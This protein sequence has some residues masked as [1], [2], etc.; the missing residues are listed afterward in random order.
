MAK[1]QKTWV[2]SPKRQPEP[3]VPEAVKAD[4]EAKANELVNSIIKPMHVKPPCE[5][6]QF[7]YIVDIYSKWYRNYFYFCSKYACPG[8]NAISPF[9]EAKFARLEYIGNGRFNL[10]YMRHTGKWWEIYPELSLE[11]CLAAIRDEPH[12]LP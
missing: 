8:P 4:L 6:E 5:D 12:F 10:S 11:E 9:F 7:N 2:Y 1:R 3:K